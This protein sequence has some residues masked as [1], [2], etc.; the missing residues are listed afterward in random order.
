M[1]KRSW[2][3]L[4]VAAPILVASGCVPTMMAPTVTATPGPGKLPADLASDQTA[5]TAQA[6]QQMAPAVQAAN[7]QVTGT[8]LQNILTGSGDNAVTVNAQAKATLQR[9]YNAA[10]SACMY[11]KGENVP[12][13]YMQPVAAAE[14]EA[15]PAPVTHHKRYAH[16]KPT[17]NA[18][19][20][21]NANFV[22][23]A[24]T[25]SSGG[26]S[27]VEPAPAP[28]AAPASAGGSSGSGGFAVP[29]PVTH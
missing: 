25:A 16:K 17:T 24:P 5:C 29:A 11:A 21:A 28:A 8:A 22:E 26:G 4:A 2:L 12:P 19:S 27:F 3:S 15:E 20:T 7:N 14:P 18:T 1:R 6:N 23:P 13:D 9:Q 10:Y